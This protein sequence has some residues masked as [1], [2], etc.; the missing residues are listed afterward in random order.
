MSA[1]RRVAAAA[2]RRSRRRRKVDRLGDIQRMSWRNVA[3]G[4]YVVPCMKLLDG[5]AEAVG[6]ADQ[7]IAAAQCVA[8]LAER[9]C[10]HADGNDE[11]VVHLQRTGGSDI[12]HFRD[13]V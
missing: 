3:G 4:G 12:V 1:V 10:G 2:A 6:H 5:N 11:F 9:G 13:L 7:R 8:L